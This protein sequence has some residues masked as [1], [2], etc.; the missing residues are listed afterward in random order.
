[1]P[2]SPL[3]LLNDENLERFSKDVAKANEEVLESRG[4]HGGDEKSSVEDI[5]NGCQ[6]TF[7]HNTSDQF[8]AE[9]QEISLSHVEN[10]A[11]T[12]Y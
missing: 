4:K 8:G 1:M 10:I 7:D 11:S 12:L 5:H 6:T 2:F 3:E 9:I